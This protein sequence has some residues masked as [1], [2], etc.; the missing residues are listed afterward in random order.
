MRRGSLSSPAAGPGVSVGVVMMLNKLIATPL[1]RFTEV[2]DAIGKGDL[3]Q[4]A[5]IGTTCDGESRDEVTRLGRTL[6]RMVKGLK[7]LT[8]QIG[9]ITQT[10]NSA[11]G[12]DHVV[13]PGTGDE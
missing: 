10:L 12:G 8:S 9:G 7:E 13:Y 5:D 1:T 4:Q 2:A 6:N 11:L 3:T